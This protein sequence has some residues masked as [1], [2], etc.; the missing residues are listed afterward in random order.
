M[1]TGMD[2]L[3]FATT[4]Y[5]SGLPNKL[6]DGIDNIF[7]FNSNNFAQLPANKELLDIDNKHNFVKQ[8]FE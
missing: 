2:P 8:I 1:A 3:T 4:F 6:K 7:D 5:Q